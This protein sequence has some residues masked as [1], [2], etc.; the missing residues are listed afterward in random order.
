MHGQPIGQTQTDQGQFIGQVMDAIHQEAET[1]RLGTGDGLGEH[2]ARIECCGSDER[3]AYVGHRRRLPFLARRMHDLYVALRPRD[4]GDSGAIP[5]SHRGMAS[6]L[7]GQLLRREA[8]DVERAQGHQQGTPQHDDRKEHAGP[9][10][11]QGHRHPRHVHEQPIHGIEAPHRALRVPGMRAYNAST[12][13][14]RRER[15]DD[16]LAEGHEGRRTRS[17]RGRKPATRAVTDRA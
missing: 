7:A 17:H 10:E 2:N 6:D 3:F 16:A 12:N 1:V 5:D 11:Q 13:A 14:V 8:T 15:L 9:A 4:M